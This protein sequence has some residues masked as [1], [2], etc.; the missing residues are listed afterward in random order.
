MQVPRVY[1]SENQL[2]RLADTRRGLGNRHELD[3]QLHRDAV[4]ESG[5]RQSRLAGSFTSV[6]K[7]ADSYV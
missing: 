1:G 2:S 3:G 4:H 7:Y 5:N 6:R